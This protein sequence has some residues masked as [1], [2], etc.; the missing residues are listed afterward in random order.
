MCTNIYKPT[1]YT[2]GSQWGD[3]DA[4]LVPLVRRTLAGMTV[5]CLLAGRSSR[6]VGASRLIWGRTARRMSTV[7][8]QISHHPLPPTTVP[9]CTCAAQICSR[10]FLL[11]IPH[12]QLTSASLNSYTF[13]MQNIETVLIR[14]STELFV[15]I[16]K[17]PTDVR[18]YGKQD[19][20]TGRVPRP[21]PL[22]R[23]LAP[24]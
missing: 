4:S 6:R 22:L 21:L 2:R 15:I 5:A 9:Y 18:N 7:L 23:W 14:N 16:R 12:P 11:S 19:A 10:E 3:R 20:C 17:R 13:H 8:W 24:N 1:S